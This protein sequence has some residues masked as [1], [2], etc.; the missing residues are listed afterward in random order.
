MGVELIGINLPSTYFGWEKQRKKKEEEK[1]LALLCAGYCDVL[2]YQGD[3]L[4]H[5][6]AGTLPAIIYIR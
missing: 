6:L 5:R 3:I 2:I 1:E 4:T